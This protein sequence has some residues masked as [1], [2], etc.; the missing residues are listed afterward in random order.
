MNE[1]EHYNKAKLTKIVDMKP[2]SQ[3]DLVKSI[4]ETHPSLKD[5]IRIIDNSR[6]NAADEDCVLVEDVQEHTT[7][8]KVFKKFWDKVKNRI[9]YKLYKELKAEFVLED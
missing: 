7:D 3:C 1:V 4:K 8:N 2:R 9:D 5:C 6:Y